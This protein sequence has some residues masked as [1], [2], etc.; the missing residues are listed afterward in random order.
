MAKIAEL[1]WRLRVASDHCGERDD[2]GPSAYLSAHLGSAPLPASTGVQ[3]AKGNAPVVGSAVVVI[4][5]VSEAIPQLADMPLAEPATGV[6]F[7][8]RAARTA[9][10]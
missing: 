3:V 10:T 7:A 4:G 9:A 2:A 5:P 1:R 8:K 6:S